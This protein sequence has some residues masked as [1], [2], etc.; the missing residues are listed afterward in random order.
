MICVKI[1]EESYSYDIHS[2]I[3][4][5]YPAEDIK[6][7][8]NDEDLNSDSNMPEFYVYAG[9]DKIKTGIDSDGTEGLVKE[10]A[11]S[12]SLSKDRAA[13]KSELKRS[14]YRAL[15]EYTG[16]ELPWGTLTG[17]RPT[18]LAMTCLDEG[19]SEDAAVG[20]MK[21][22]YLCSDTK[23]KLATDIATRERQIIKNIGADEKGY[24][25]YIGIPFCPS[26]C[27]Y[28]SFMSYPIAAHRGA[29]DSYIDAVKKEL[30]FVA[31]S[32]AGRRLDSVYIGG[33]TPTTL[34]SE[35][36]KDLIGY[37]HEKIDL[38]N[39]KEFTVEAGRADSIDREK[40]TV[41]RQMGVD[42]ISVNPQTFNED[43]LKLIGRKAT[44]AETIEAFYLARE[45]G[46]DNINMDIIL[47]LPG[48]NIDDIKYTLDKI[49]EL[50][51]NDL[52]VHS[53]AV[54]RGSKLA[55]LLLENKKIGDSN[56]MLRNDG[57][58]YEEAMRLTEQTAARIGL[59]PYY[60]YRQKNIRGNLENTGYA[61]DGKA[62]I[63]NI[64]MMEEV[65][66]IVA[67]GAGTVSKRVYVQDDNS[68]RIERCDTHKDLKL[69]L[70]NTEQMIDRKRKLYGID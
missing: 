3:K 1:N 61:E 52:T 18:K 23:A 45:V 30:D 58:D 44:A 4:A 41:L 2:L 55:E 15:S 32:F 26:T 65:Q 40:L 5:F 16:Q 43:T 11:V 24:S 19:M 46:F 25:L 9:M 53:L 47:G 34:S 35:R 37:V 51:P 60:L 20:Y 33:G 39:I 63:Y 67:C 54:K 42:R 10:V 62:G 8:L 50:K 38:S 12:D 49:E 68:V 48:E 36:L 57:I 22:F 29:V 59:S 64:L 27:L 69:Y 66:D 70:E 14:L 28:C 13:Y 56:V 17:I 7:V 21:D 6:V 31:G